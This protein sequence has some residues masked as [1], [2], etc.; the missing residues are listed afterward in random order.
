MGD[1]A[2]TTY[3][4]GSVANRSDIRDK[5][6]VR[7]TV[8]GLDFIKSL[9]PVDYKWDMREDYRPLAPNKDDFDTDELY[10]EAQLQWLEDVKLSNITHDGTHKRT[11]YHQ[12]FIAQE[13]MALGSDFGGIQ[14]HKIKGGDDVLSICYD[15]LIAPLVKA[16][17]E[18]EARVKELE[19]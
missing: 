4:Y 2:T 5:A 17:Q 12:G 19:K 7:D 13:V 15:E 9:R 10:K 16:I 1:A 8:L 6:D 18:L 11:R 14:D 3:V